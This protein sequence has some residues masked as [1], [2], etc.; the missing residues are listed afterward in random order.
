VLSASRYDEAIR[1]CDDGLSVDPSESLIIAERVKVILRTAIISQ[2]IIMLLQ[3]V[4]LKSEADKKLR[5]K[6]HE[7]RKHKEGRRKIMEAVK[8]RNIK[9]A[10]ARRLRRESDDDDDEAVIHMYDVT[11]IPTPTGTKVYV[12]ADSK[13]CVRIA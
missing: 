9:L 7:S 13:V 3:A 6:D 4:K 10:E 5:K 2:R 1:W 8:A 12:D 11:Q